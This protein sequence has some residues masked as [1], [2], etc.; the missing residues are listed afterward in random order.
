MKEWQFKKIAS[1][2]W[3]EQDS[4][5]SE[6]WASFERAQWKFFW[7]LGTAQTRAYGSCSNNGLVLPC[8]F[9][10]KK[11][12]EALI[13]SL[14]SNDWFMADGTFILALNYLAPSQPTF[15]HVFKSEEKNFIKSFE[16]KWGNCFVLKPLGWW[17]FDG[18]LV[19]LEKN[20]WRRCLLHSC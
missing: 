19:S 14:Y 5:L 8:S 17:W 15:I 18:V 13:G 9:R 7:S 20:Y 16:E 12:S 3:F 6:L 2:V 1:K 10:T 11:A 4:A